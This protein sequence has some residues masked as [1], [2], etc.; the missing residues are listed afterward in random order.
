MLAEQYK[1]FNITNNSFLKT[2]KEMQVV[3]GDTKMLC[4]GKLILAIVSLKY[5]MKRNKPTI[6]L[7]GSL[8]YILANNFGVAKI[9]NLYD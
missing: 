4:F 1:D 2:V 6:H 5:K 8:H 7:V 9:D 3:G